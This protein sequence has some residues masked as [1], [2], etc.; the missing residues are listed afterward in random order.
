[1]LCASAPCT[2]RPTASRPRAGSRTLFR[3][4]TRWRQGQGPKAPRR[5]IDQRPLPGTR[6]PSGPGLEPRRAG[7]A[8]LQKPGTRHPSGPDPHRGWYT[9]TQA[10][11]V[12]LLAL[13]A[14]CCLESGFSADRACSSTATRGEI[15][16]K[17]RKRQVGQTNPR[18]LCN[19]RPW[20][21][22]WPHASCAREHAPWPALCS[23]QLLASR[24]ALARLLRRCAC[25]ASTS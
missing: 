25:A 19:E 23:W 4:A 5:P 18:R 3:S 10:P 20:E 14:G 7:G 22:S 15:L 1:M 16:S 24:K 2:F 12:L 9:A 6:H 11:L 8:H 17:P 21:G 13:P